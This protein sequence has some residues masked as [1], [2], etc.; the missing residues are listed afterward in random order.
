M[1]MHSNSSSMQQFGEHFVGRKRAV[2]YTT[3]GYG[4][5]Y[6]WVLRKLTSENKTHT[7][8]TQYVWCC[9]ITKML[10]KIISLSSQA[11]KRI[12]ELYLYVTMRG[13]EKKKGKASMPKGVWLTWNTDLEERSQKKRFSVSQSSKPQTIIPYTE[14]YQVKEKTTKIYQYTVP[15]NN[16][17]PTTAHQQP[18]QHKQQQSL[19]SSSIILQ[20]QQQQQQLE[21][22]GIWC[23]CGGAGNVFR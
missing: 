20:Q 4:G 13:E 5:S 16:Q 12:R 9:T 18:K 6:S 23:K 19:Y 17:P 7:T 8:H 21:G 22:C 15:N 1:A 11:A 10:A 3:Q 14:Y 2:P